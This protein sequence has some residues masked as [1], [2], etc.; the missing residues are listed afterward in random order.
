MCCRFR[1]S[2]SPKGKF[3]DIILPKWMTIN[4]TTETPINS[5]PLKIKDFWGKLNLNL[6]QIK[7][8]FPL[9]D[10]LLPEVIYHVAISAAENNNWNVTVASVFYCHHNR[11]ANCNGIRLLHTVAL[12]LVFSVWFVAILNVPI[13]YG[14]H[15]LTGEWINKSK[16]S[17]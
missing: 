8:Q 13:G 7:L 3:K 1:N 15:W 10:S 5:V 12:L 16:C 4:M 6:S 2:A 14:L 17:L 11:I 9:L